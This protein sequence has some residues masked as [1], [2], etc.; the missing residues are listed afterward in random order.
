VVLVVATTVVVGAGY[1]GW[2]APTDSRPSGSRSDGYAA[3]VDGQE[4]QR[5]IGAYEDRARAHPNV[6]D[7]A[8]LGQLYS[9]KGRQTGDVG[10]YLQ[11]EHAIGEALALDPTDLGTNIEMAGVRYT[12]H[13]FTAALAMANRTLAVDPKSVAALVVAGDAQLELGSYGRAGEAYARVASTSPDAPAIEVR[14]ARLA[15]IQGNVELARRTAA[16]AEADAE[17]TALGG[18]DLAYY[19]AFAGQVELDSGNYAR[20]AADYRQALEEAPDYYVALAGM[21]R[22]LAL[23]GRTAEAIV[24]YERAVAVVPQPDFLSALGDLYTLRGEAQKAQVEYGTV[25]VVAKLAQINRQVYNRLLALYDADHDVNTAEA[26]QLTSAE[27]A[28][29]KDVYGYDAYAW[30]LYANGDYA[31][32]ATAAASAL[33]DGTVDPKVL[34]HAGMIARAT[35]DV[36][37]ARADLSRALAIS[38]NFD[39]RQ[40]PRARAALRGVL[41]SVKAGSSS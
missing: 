24:F 10:T 1:I 23:Q 35:G 11:A 18:P 6:E 37:R 19:E 7:L 22:A 41:A 34:Y 36:D 3:T 39:P 33:A 25:E 26:V 14:Q 28:V 30:A 2:S 29:R 31:R 4:L 15:F 27:L 8:F 5:M 40:A 16:K 13:D 20:G 32:A 21:G 17:A 38:P 12:T 9:Q